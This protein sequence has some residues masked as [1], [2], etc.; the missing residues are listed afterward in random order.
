MWNVSES[1]AA[2]KARELE[3]VIAAASAGDGS[4]R[5]SVGASAGIVPLMGD[6]TPEAISDAADK[7]MYA[8]KKERRG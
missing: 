3:T 6:T 8:R 7:A 2:A 1:H 5:Y 4:T